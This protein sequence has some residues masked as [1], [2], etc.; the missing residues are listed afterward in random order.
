MT[1]LQLN[2]RSSRVDNNEN[3]SRRPLSALSASVARRDFNQLEAFLRKAMKLPE[4]YWGNWQTHLDAMRLKQ[5][6]TAVL[7]IH[8]VVSFDSNRLLPEHF[9]CEGD[10]E[11][12]FD[13]IV[14]SWTR[15]GGKRSPSLEQSCLCRDRVARVRALSI[16]PVIWR[17]QRVRVS[18]KSVVRGG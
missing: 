1:A 11:H 16:G 3:D 18:L 10:A 6:L 15:A 17:C 7:T 5:F 12:S 14:A 8:L 2:R 13:K 4:K 9:C